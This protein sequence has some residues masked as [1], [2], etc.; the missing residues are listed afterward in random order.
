MGKPYQD[1]VLPK[2]QVEPADFVC[3][4]DAASVR[5]GPKVLETNVAFCEQTR[6]D[7]AVPED[8]SFLHSSACENQTLEFPSLIGRGAMRA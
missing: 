8:Q 2:T 3:L 7:C 5:A 4:E 1:A 6:R